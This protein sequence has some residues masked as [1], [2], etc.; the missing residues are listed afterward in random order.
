MST[1]KS[2]HA[3]KRLRAW[4]DFHGV[5]VSALAVTMG[6]HK[7]SIYRWQR[8]DLPPFDKMVKLAEH[9]GIAVTEWSKP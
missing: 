6:V 4:R 3:A 7:Q 9:T 1:S 8:G 5:S 2:E